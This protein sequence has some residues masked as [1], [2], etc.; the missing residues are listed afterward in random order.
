M[1]AL[2]T[3]VPAVRGPGQGWSSSGGEGLLEEETVAPAE[4]GLPPAWLVPA[5][6]ACVAGGR[7]AG[8]QGAPMLGSC[9]LSKN[10]PVFSSELGLDT[11]CVYIV[12]LRES[13]LYKRE[14]RLFP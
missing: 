6:P 13:H 9:E 8:Q 10:R 3:G 1:R 2:Y 4:W 5:C 14:E 11:G 7:V 12:V